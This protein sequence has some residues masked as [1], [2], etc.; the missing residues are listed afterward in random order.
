MSGHQSFQVAGV[1]ACKAGWLLAIVEATRHGQYLFEPK[2][3]FVAEDFAAGL[4]ATVDCKLVCIDIP[5]GLSEGDRPRQCDIAAR[6]VLGVKRASSVFPA[7]IRACVSYK[8]YIAANA[9][10]RRVTGKGISKQSF[11]IL[12]RSAK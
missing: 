6:K 11:S 4:L 9:I 2:R 3:L 12:S 10:S 7:P 8:N 5:I 1:N